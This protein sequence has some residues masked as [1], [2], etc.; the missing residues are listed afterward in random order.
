MEPVIEI[1]CQSFPLLYRQESQTVHA[2]CLASLP[3]HLMSEI[4]L[5][6][7]CILFY[8]VYYFLASLHHS[9]ISPYQWTVKVF[10]IFYYCKQYYIEQPYMYICHFAHVRAESSWEQGLVEIAK[11]PSTDVYQVTFHQRPTRV[12]VSP[13]P[14][15]PLFIVLSKP[16][17]GLGKSLSCW[18]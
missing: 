2:F 13:P 11:L 5:Y 8:I 4:I 7:L 18:N 6:Q 12:P 9:I 16:L 3:L 14:W 1:H 17:G 15:N 10:P